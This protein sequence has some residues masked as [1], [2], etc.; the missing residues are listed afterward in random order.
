M[1]SCY[2]T[3]RTNYFQVADENAFRELMK[4][5]QGTEDK[6]KV[7]ER[8]EDGVKLFGFGCGSDIAGLDEEY[9]MRA[10]GID[11]DGDVV[12][13]EDDFMEGRYDVFTD[14]LQKLIAKDDAVIILEA[15]SEKLRYV[16]G[17]ATI[18]TQD[19][20]EHLDINRLAIGRAAEMLN[21]PDWN[22]KLEY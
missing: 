5:V 15:S 9:F 11:P 6:V 16:N 19:R 22:T 7:F 3:I 2:C 10:H 12:L 20:V 13:D 21:N 4:H 14:C 1:A 17:L 8:E 18:I